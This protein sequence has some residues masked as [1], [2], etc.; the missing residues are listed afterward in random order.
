AGDREGEYFEVPT[1]TAQFRD[2]ELAL[3]GEHQLEN[4]TAA[5]ALAEIL[6]SRGLPIDEAAIRAGLRHVRWPGRLQV[7]G[8]R[9]WVVVDGAHNADSFGRMLTALRRHFAFERL[10]LVLGLMADKDLSGI[11]ATIGAG[12]VDAVIATAVT[13]PRAAAPETIATGVR[14]IAPTTRVEAVLPV[15]AALEAGPKGAHPPEPARV[16][17]SLHLA[18]TAP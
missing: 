3:L 11:A 16:A 10:I 17:G 14:D 1:A 4:A 5:V 7:V 9:P 18:G 13:H 6:K 15:P 2:V 12:D 8:R